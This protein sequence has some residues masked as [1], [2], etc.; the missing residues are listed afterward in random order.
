G[1]GGGGAARDGGATTELPPSTPPKTPPDT[2]PATPPATPIAEGAAGRSTIGTMTFG[3]AVGATSTSVET[4]G[5]ITDAVFLGAAVGGSAGARSGAGGG[6]SGV[7]IVIKTSRLGSACGISSGIT[8][9]PR[10]R[11]PWKITELN[12]DDFLYLSG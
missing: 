6:G 7:S 9:S 8:T 12:T 5:C 11:N 1:G 2:P 10:T 3:I 4:V